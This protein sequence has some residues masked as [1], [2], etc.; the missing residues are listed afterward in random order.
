MPV[1]TYLDPLSTDALKRILTEPKNA[2]VKQYEKLFELDG[3][4]LIVEET[5]IDYIVEKAEEFG[6]GARGLRTICEAIFTDDMFNL[7]SEV[8]EG[9][10][11]EL[12]VDRKYA[13]SKLSKLS[14]SKLK[15]A[16]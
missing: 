13:I 11:R 9:E 12:R 6:L 3:I 8:E 7:P 16:S 2:L 10:K 15:A 5:A 1:L 14:P 4:E